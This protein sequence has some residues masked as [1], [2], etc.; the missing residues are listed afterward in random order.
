VKSCPEE[1]RHGHI[2]PAGR[3]EQEQTEEQPR[4]LAH[5]RG[6]FWAREEPASSRSESRHTDS[7]TYGA[8][9]TQTPQES[10]HQSSS[11]SCFNSVSL[12]CSREL[13][14]LAFEPLTAATKQQSDL[15]ATSALPPYN[16]LPFMVPSFTTG[17]P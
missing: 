5:T 1:K 4:F 6:S 13:K 9:T 12:C 16:T 11:Q 15:W 10:H 17:S 3:S 14:V 8:P 2:C 7:G